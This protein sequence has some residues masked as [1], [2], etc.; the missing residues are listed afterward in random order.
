MLDSSVGVHMCVFVCMCVRLCAC[1]CVCVHVCV[2][3]SLCVHMYNI[4]TLSRGGYWECKWDEVRLRIGFT[5][6]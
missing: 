6:D 2:F 3:V 5:T 4:L 1:V